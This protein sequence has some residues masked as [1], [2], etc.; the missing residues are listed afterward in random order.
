MKKLTIKILKKA[1]R[2]HRVYLDQKK[3]RKQTCSSQIQAARIHKRDNNGKS[4]FLNRGSETPI[5]STSQQ[6]QGRRAFLR[7]LCQATCPIS[8]RTISKGS[9]Q[10]HQVV[11]PSVRR[12]LKNPPKKRQVSI[13]IRPDLHFV[14]ALRN[15]KGLPN[16]TEDIR[17]SMIKSM[18]NSKVH[19]RMKLRL[20]K[21]QI[22]NML[23]TL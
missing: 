18:N 21:S 3:P 7:S 8:R 9:I 16:V 6:T 20:T 10:A 13:Q 15:Q 19:S 5:E 12:Q 2:V 4:S 11:K 14:K 22:T 17:T 23:T 1:K